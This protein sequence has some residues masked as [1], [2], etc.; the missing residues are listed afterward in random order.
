MATGAAALQR[1]HGDP[2]IDDVATYGLPMRPPHIWEGGA[3]RPFQKRA[4]NDRSSVGVAVC[5][6]A[7]FLSGM[8]SAT[9]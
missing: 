4:V 8:P 7:G 1:V 2:W 6:D 3:R 5:N 9:S